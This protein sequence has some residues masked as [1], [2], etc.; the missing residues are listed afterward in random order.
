MIRVTILAATPVAIALATASHAADRKAP[1]T[2]DARVKAEFAAT[3]TNKDGT[4]SRA[5]VKSRIVR[6]DA[7]RG[8]MSPAQVDLLSTTWFDRADGNKDG[9]VTQP[10]MQKL[11]TAIA[12]RYDTN[13]DGVVSLAERQAARRETLA[14]VGAAQAQTK[15]ARRQER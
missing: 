6:M 14:E 10:E 4:L 1:P 13:G 2:G 7:G 9:K 12:R 8:R 15:S 3:D 11:L 5:E